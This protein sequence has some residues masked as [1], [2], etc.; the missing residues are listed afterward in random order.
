MPGYLLHQGA[1]VMCSH[2]G[3][4]QPVLPDARVKVSNQAVVTQPFFHTI[5]GCSSTPPCAL[6]QWLTAA[7]RV[8]AS[9]QPILLRDS[10]ATCIPNGTGVKIIE[11][12][13]RVKGI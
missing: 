9:G 3:K 2:G 13:T 11:T 8:R 5:A 12:Q 6:A 10:Q 7:T 1:T 4:V